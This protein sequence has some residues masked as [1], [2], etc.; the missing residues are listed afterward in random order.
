MNI[1]VIFTGGTIGSTYKDGYISTEASTRYALIEKYKAQSDH[2]VSFVTDAPYNILSE[3]LTGSYINK[4]IDCLRRHEKDDIEGIIITHGT[5][6]LQY[7]AAALGMIFRS[8]DKP[9]VF[10]SSNYVL[11]DTRANGL[12]N[13]SNAVAFICKQISNGIFVSYDNII[14]DALCLFPH[15]QYDDKLYSLDDNIFGSFSDGI[16]YKNDNYV[17]TDLEKLLPDFIISDKKLFS[18]CAPV[19]CVRAVPGQLY[20]AISEDTRAV[21]LDSYH[22]GT[23]NT[24]THTLANFVHNATNKKIPVYLTG[25]QDTIQYESTKKYDSIGIKVLPKLSIITAYMLLWLYYS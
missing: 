2:R 4:L 10:V 22:S 19:L 24:A 25:L 14:H 21:L 11:E 1:L 9:V 23:L 15:M 6:T 16:F 5:D 18:E 7:S 8:I 12:N 3:N 17:S 13:F 20:P